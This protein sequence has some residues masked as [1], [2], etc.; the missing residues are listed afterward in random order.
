MIIPKKVAESVDTFA[1]LKYSSL[2][3][4][5]VLWMFYGFDLEIL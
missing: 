2:G 3:L 1:F 4:Y 5:F